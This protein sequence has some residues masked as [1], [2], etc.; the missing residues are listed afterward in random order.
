MVASPHRIAITNT[1]LI[2]GTGAPPLAGATV[3]VEDGRVRLAGP[4]AQVPL[5]E[6][7]E[8]IDG[9]GK[10]LIPG[11]TDVHVHVALSAGEPALRHWLAWGVTTVR[12]L[13]GDPAV[14]LDLRGR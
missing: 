6:G 14:V 7:C 2:D 5:P 13:G 9:R 11:L 3:L 1:T 12:D 10:W 8:T 4:A